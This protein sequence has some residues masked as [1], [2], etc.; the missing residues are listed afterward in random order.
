MESRRHSNLVFILTFK[1]LALIVNDITKN[2][3][4]TNFIFVGLLRFPDVVKNKMCYF[5][6]YGLKF[7]FFGKSELFVGLQSP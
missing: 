3:V 2:K 4:I 1:I 5:A 6:I 7:K